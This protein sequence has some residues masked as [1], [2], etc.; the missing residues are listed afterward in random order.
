[1]HGF[2]LHVIGNSTVCLSISVLKS[3]VA[4]GL[5]LK[6]GPTVYAR[7]FYV[8]LYICMSA[9]LV[10]FVLDINVAFSLIWKG[11][12]IMLMTLSGWFDLVMGSDVII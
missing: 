1:M 7:H 4:I 3:Y 12:G 8:H 6:L 5:D 10:V 2:R 9:T 11:L